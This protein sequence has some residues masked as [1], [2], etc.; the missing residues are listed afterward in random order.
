MKMNAG[1]NIKGHWDT[2]ANVHY[3]SNNLNYSEN[4]SSS[5]SI[6][7]KFVPQSLLLKFIK[8]IY[9]HT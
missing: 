1:T 5:S 7:C 9:T 2:I 3:N 8:L 6:S 4:S